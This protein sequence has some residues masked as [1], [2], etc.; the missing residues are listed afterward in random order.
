LACAAVLSGG[1]IIL[2]AMR[3]APHA[4]PM[5][6]AAMASASDPTG[7]R[8]VGPGRLEPQ[9]GEVDLAVDVPGVLDSLPVK[10]G[11]RIAKGDILAELVNKD[12]LSR[13]EEA[14]ATLQMQ[15]AR[16]DK[17]KKGPRSEERQQAVAAIQE[18]DA[19]LLRLSRDLARQKMLY[20][21]GYASNAQLEQAQ[22]AQGVAAA[23][24]RSSAEA[25]AQIDAGPRAEDVASAEAEVKLARAKLDEA[26]AALDKTRIRAPIDGVVL[27]LY[28]HP[29]EAVGPGATS[30]VLQIGNLDRLVVRTQIDEADIA[31][32]AKGAR[33]YVTAPAF[34]GTKFGGA[35]T[36]VSPRLGAK[37]IQTG[38]PTEKRD[39]SVLDVL[40][41]LDP[42][43]RLPIGLRVDCYVFETGRAT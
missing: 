25:L 6:G 12:A 28:K 13:V 3:P 24:R 17:L 18:Q 1:A 8:V 31:R 26:K 14:G 9:S 4:M 22:S 27:R 2:W 16:L 42:D 37:T 30:A 5:D 39:A 40:V 19:A 36:D 29:G 32:I 38:A 43:V 20:G 33:A 15:M 41:T 10:E 23:K 35:V 21:R 7:A 34:P 11:D